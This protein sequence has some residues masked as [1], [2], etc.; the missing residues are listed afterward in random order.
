MI[1]VLISSLFL[2]SNTAVAFPS[3][4]FGP[5]ARLVTCQEA[6]S[7]QDER[8]SVVI[9]MHPANIHEL[10]RKILVAKMVVRLPNGRELSKTTIVDSFRAKTGRGPLKFLGQEFEL[11]MRS[12]EASGAFSRAQLLTRIDGEEFSELL[13]C[14]YSP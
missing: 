14:R 11:R 7:Q 6:F 13:M 5:G 10:Y 12:S 4:E 8:V 9:D 1:P 3:D 2:L